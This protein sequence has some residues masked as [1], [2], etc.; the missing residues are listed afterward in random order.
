MQWCWFSTNEQDL[1]NAVTAAEVNEKSDSQNLRK[2]ECVSRT[3]RL[4]RSARNLNLPQQNFNKNE[5]L[6]VRV[7]S[8]SS[9]E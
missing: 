3:S 9:A 7:D 8:S 4:A 2:R 5:K 6:Q 1:L